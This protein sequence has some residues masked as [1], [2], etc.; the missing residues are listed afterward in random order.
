MSS[1]FG[2]GFIPALVLT[3]AYAETPPSTSTTAAQQAAKQ[4]AAT[5][6][7]IGN[8]IANNGQQGLTTQQTNYST[9]LKSSVDSMMN[10]QKGQASATMLS[11]A[12]FQAAQPYSPC[13]P[14]SLSGVEACAIGSVLAGM[15][16][17]MA[18]SAGSF[19]API[20]MAWDNVCHFSSIQAACGNIPNPYAPIVQAFPAP[21]SVQYNQIIQTFQNKGFIINPRTGLVTKPDG[22]LI[23]PNSPSSVRQ[24]IGADADKKL[25]KQLAQMQKEV[26]SRLSR[27]KPD[28]YWR[29]LGLDS[30]RV[31][32]EK[33][34]ETMSGDHNRTHGAKETGSAS[35][36][37]RYNRLPEK[38]R[39]KVEISE[40]VKNYNGT[41]I[42]IAA[43]DIFKMIKRRYEIK[44]SQKIF[45]KPEAGIFKQ[46]QTSY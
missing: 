34:V 26:V 21:T 29:G 45:L 5:G 38:V 22:S 44:I 40:L 1:L 17:M 42:G 28:S 46:T 3:L 4:G 10:G 19:Q 24:A 32:G 27:V 16:G 35:R 15:S 18:T 11:G 37:V 30:L 20:Q 12:L 7:Q 39:E 2:L 25:Q 43:A 13:D 6:T 23:D 36:E 9:L 33:I 41:P 31:L 8:Q 14:S